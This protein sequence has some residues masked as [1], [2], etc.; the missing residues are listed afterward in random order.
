MEVMR[1]DEAFYAA[2][3]KQL[4]RYVDDKDKLNG[5][6]AMEG[7]V[8]TSDVNM[9]LLSQMRHTVVM[10][11]PSGPITIVCDEG[12]VRLANEAEDQ[13]LMFNED[14]VEYYIEGFQRLLGLMRREKKDA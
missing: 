3:L 5:G 6:K 10:E 11:L 14:E 8:K 7:D 1:D 4:F 9:T 12:M 2:R 13:V